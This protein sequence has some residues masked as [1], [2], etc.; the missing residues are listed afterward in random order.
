MTRAEHARLHHTGRPQ[1]HARKFTPDQ[2]R[3]IRRRVARGESQEKLA[4]EFKRNSGIIWK[5]VHRVTY[6][7]V[8]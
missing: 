7:E 1:H 4:R 6:A 8:V 5:I 3:E 2:I